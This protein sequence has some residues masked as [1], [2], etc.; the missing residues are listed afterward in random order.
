MKS[1]CC[2]LKLNPKATKG[3]RIICNLEKVLNHIYLFS[4]NLAL[5]PE[6]EI[7]MNI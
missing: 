5:I 7:S 3:I 4:E 2:I 6:T 1:V